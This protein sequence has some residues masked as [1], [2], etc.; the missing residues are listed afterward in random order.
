MSIF[1]TQCDVG[2]VCDPIELLSTL[3]TCPNPAYPVCVPIDFFFN[4]PQ[5]NQCN[6]D[7]ASVSEKQLLTYSNQP[8]PSVMLMS[9]SLGY[10]CKQSKPSRGSV[11]IALYGHL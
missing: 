7:P 11:C 3:L 5:P 10:I 8:Q 4:L 2:P 9:A 1:S 6:V